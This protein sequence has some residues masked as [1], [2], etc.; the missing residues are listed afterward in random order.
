[1]RLKRKDEET[2]LVETI[3]KN[4]KIISKLYKEMEQLTKDLEYLKKNQEEKN[5]REHRMYN[6]ALEKYA[7]FI[8]P[9]EASTHSSSSS[10]GPSTVCSEYLARAPS[11]PSRPQAVAKRY[12]SAVLTRNLCRK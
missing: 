7:D 11:G 8:R 9:G 10:T 6:D 3:A 5:E 2:V 12:S 1:M 4:N